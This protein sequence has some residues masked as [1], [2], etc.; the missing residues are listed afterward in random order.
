MKY[1]WKNIACIWLLLVIKPSLWTYNL[2]RCPVFP[3]ETWADG[4]FISTSFEWVPCYIKTASHEW[5]KSN[6]HKRKKYEWGLHHRIDEYTNHRGNGRQ[7]STRYAVLI[8]TATQ[9]LAE[10]MFILYLPWCWYIFMRIT[11]NLQQSNLCC[12]V[13][14]LCLSM[15]ENQSYVMC[16]S[17]RCIW[18]ITEWQYMYNR[19]SVVYYVL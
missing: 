16:C 19:T 10:N 6:I 8:K 4:S 18:V 9:S 3:T 1:R 5:G 13:F 11:W 7:D 12:V 2:L 15:E 17:L 14:M